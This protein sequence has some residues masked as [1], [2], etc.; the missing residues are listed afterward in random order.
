MSIYSLDHR[1]HIVCFLGFFTYLVYYLSMK[2]LTVMKSEPKVGLNLCYGYPSFFLSA[3][4]VFHFACLVISYYI[5]LF[6]PFIG[7]YSLIISLI[8][9]VSNLWLFFGLRNFF[10]NFYLFKTG[11]L[12]KYFDGRFKVLY[13]EDMSDYKQS[14]KWLGGTY[15]FIKNSGEKIFLFQGFLKC[16]SELSSFIQEKLKQFHKD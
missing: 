9:L 16:E 14:Y 12:I 15:S 2:Q 13:F 1:L 8:L 4:G 6:Y 5:L 11:L 10:A 7:I 3:V